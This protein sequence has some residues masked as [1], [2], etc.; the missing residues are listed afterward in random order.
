[1]PGSTRSIGVLKLR[2]PNPT[3]PICHPSSSI[4]RRCHFVCVLVVSGRAP[5]YDHLYQAVQ[6][7]RCT[8][9]KRAS[10]QRQS[11]S[12]N[13][14]PHQPKLRKMALKTH[15]A[16]RKRRD[17]IQYLTETCNRRRMIRHRLSLTNRGT[18]QKLV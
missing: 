14:A 11:V 10:G 9:S 3:P 15:P 1:M 12:V 16:T 5:L 13:H 7:V 8:N 2:V 6:G 18:S 17:R 4:P